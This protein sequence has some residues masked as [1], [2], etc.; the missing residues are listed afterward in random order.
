M[1]SNSRPNRPG[2]HQFPLR[3]VQQRLPLP[4]PQKH[5]QRKMQL[6]LSKLSLGCHCR[7]LHLQQPAAGH[8][9]HWRRCRLLLLQG[10]VRD[11]SGKLLRMQLHGLRNGLYRNCRR[12]ERSDDL[13]VSRP[14]HHRRQYLLPPLPHRSRRFA[15][16][17]LVSMPYRIHLEQ[18]PQH[19]PKL[20]WSHRHPRGHQ[21]QSHPPGLWM[22][23]QQQG[24]GRYDQ[25][26]YRCLR[27][28]RRQLHELRRTARGHRRPRCRIGHH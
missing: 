19:M 2:R 15:H 11:L 20:H 12:R 5:H 16:R 24:L 4:R 17:L 13:Q 14:Q 21:C 28:K 23:R 22:H 27:Q 9:W 25:Y 6:S 1:R 18:Y 3:T 10:V 7:P 26:L 8:R